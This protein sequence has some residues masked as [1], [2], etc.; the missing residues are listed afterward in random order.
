[1]H[2]NIANIVSPTDINTSAVIDFAVTFL[3]VQHVILCG[4][5]SCGGAAAALSDNRLGGVLDTWLTPMKVLRNAHTD[6]LNA[7]KD[8]AA[9]GVRLAEFNVEAGVQVL[10]ANAAIQEA[11][12]DRGLKVHGCLFD[13]GSGRLRD[14]GF[15]NAGKG[16]NGVNGFSGQEVVRG[17]HGML[18]FRGTNGASLGTR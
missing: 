3:K 12:K 10:L 2:R 11:I 5:S 7:I 9:R 1:V 8:S 13:I 18:V 14:L 16:A 4:H 15:G 6:E 17:N